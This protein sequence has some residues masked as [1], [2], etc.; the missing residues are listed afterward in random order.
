MKGSFV[1]SFITVDKDLKDCIVNSYE[2][3][4][5]QV[6]L[7][8]LSNAKDALNNIDEKD[9]YLHISSYTIDKYAVIEIVDNG[10]GIDKD[11]INRVFEPY[12]TT[13]HKSQGTGLGLYMTHKILIDSMKG[14]INIENH[15]FNKYNNCTKVTLK[16]P[17]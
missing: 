2:N 7:N 5:N 16:I 6:L 10:G 1:N 3:E 4:L 12:F 11:I 9:R 15:S 17:I 14:L 8:I 13:K